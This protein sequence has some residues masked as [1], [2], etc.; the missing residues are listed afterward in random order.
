[1][2]YYIAGCVFSV[3]FPGLSKRIREYA[4]EHYGLNVLRCCVPNWKVKIFED[5]M[6]EGSLRDSWKALPHSK[7]FTPDDEVWSM[8]HNCTNIIEEHYR[9]VKAGCPRSQ[10]VYS[11]ELTESLQLGTTKSDLAKR[12][13]QAGCPR[14][15]FVYSIELTE[16]LQLGTTKSDLAKR[17]PQV[18]SLWEL[19]DSDDYFP[20]PDYSGMK[21]IVQDCW[22]S[23]ERSEE[24]ASCIS[25]VSRKVSELKQHLRLQKSFVNADAVLYAYVF[26][27]LCAVKII[28]SGLYR[29]QAREPLPA[30]MHCHKKAPDCLSFHCH[31][32]HECNFRRFSALLPERCRT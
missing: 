4:K 5:K 13:P 24:Q 25:S 11:I 21:V 8:C 29:S 23:R 27:K 14:S 20:F 17:H 16:S 19:I 12:R 22:R 9:G 10:F 32:P 6:P 2:N 7:K 18:H 15:Q 3:R 26:R 28:L 1:M 31:F 30:R